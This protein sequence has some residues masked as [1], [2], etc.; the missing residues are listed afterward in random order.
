MEKDNE[1]EVDL[2][3]VYNIINNPSF[4]QFLLLNT[5][6]WT[7]AAWIIQILLDAF[8]EASQQLEIK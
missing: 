3:D 4:S 8:E 6:N 7:S 2:Q 5:A 1:I